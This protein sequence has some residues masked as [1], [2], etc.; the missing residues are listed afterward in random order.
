M[1]VRRAPNATRHLLS[2]VLFPE[3]KAYPLLLK[4]QECLLNTRAF[5]TTREDIQRTRNIGISAHIDSGKTTLTE[6]VLRYTNR[7][8]QIHE[9]RG[10]DGVGATMDSMELE[11]ERGITIQS[12]ATYCTWNGHA[13]NLIDTPGHVDFTIEV[14]RALRVLDG[15]ILVICSVGGVQSQ[16]ITV[17]RQ[18]RR[19]RVPRLIFINK[20]D[21][22]GADPAGVLKQ[23]RDKLRLN[24]AMVQVPIGLENQHEGVVDVVRMRALHFDGEDGE[25]MVESD[26]PPEYYDKAREVRAKL[27]EV[28]AEVDEEVGEAFLVEEE[29]TI[30]VLQ[31]AIRRATVK[32]DFVPVF[33]GS[34]YKN[35]GVQALLN[36]VVD[37]L[38]SPL[39]VEN[40]AYPALSTPSSEKPR[41]EEKVVLEA[42]SSF[43]L[44]GLA[45]KLEESR[46]GQLTYLRVYQGSIRKGDQIINVNSG[47]KVKVP[48]LVR[49]S[50]NNM[51]D[52][53]EAGAGDIVA[54]FG[55]ECSSGDTF[56]SPD[57]AKVTLESMHTPETV[58]SLAVAPASKESAAAFTKALQRF[59]K[60]DPT[61]K[62]HQDADTGETI[63]SGMGELHLDVYIERM[64][65][66]YK[67]EVRVGA[68]R[69]NY[70]E[71][72]TQRAPYDYTLKKQTGG[73]GQYAKVV[74]YVEPLLTESGELAKKG[75]EFRN[76]IVGNIIPPQFLPGIEKG[77]KEALNRG[78]LI[79]A[80]VEGLRVVLTDGNTHAVDSSE[81]AFKMASVYA[82][83]QGFEQARPVILEPIMLVE[84][85]VPNE[86][87]GSV[88]GDVNRRKGVVNESNVSVDFV[89]IKANI[90]LSSM[91]GYSTELRSMTQG[92]GEFSMEYDR[93]DT[94]SG[95]IQKK[96]IAES[97]T[98]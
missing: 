44:V 61:F 37:Y 53:A 67:C 5:S 20:L 79:G 46:F 49:M 36:G 68:P 9:V 18:M 78:S 29:P 47:K 90:P 92:K 12:A 22:S 88:V 51:E 1:L 63:I 82:F 28:L 4:V 98:A 77:F 60:E 17:D 83:R 6:R 32:L 96:L 80:C 57:S 23:A 25:H 3:R 54:I 93:H 66:E 65:R 56:I 41:A 94:V 30:D 7:I 48:R 86:F 75:Y 87:Q 72:I 39:E 59:R 71:T 13:I 40:L 64:K 21:R 58:M 50:S 15:A 42:D 16:T 27:I 34:A 35:K 26:V 45:F 14:E 10:R 11:R 62:V 43:P 69:V 8:S 91:F 24:A 55:V 74:G 31:R 38:P 76:D 84:I 52:I 73:S 19:Y 2:C 70:L 81:L 33:C 89:T 97:K 85:T 95:E